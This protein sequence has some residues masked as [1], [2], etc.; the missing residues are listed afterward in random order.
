MTIFWP[1][2]LLIVVVTLYISWRMIRSFKSQSMWSVVMFA[3]MGTIGVLASV[4]LSQE[5]YLTRAEQISATTRIESKVPIPYSTKSKTGYELQ[6]DGNAYITYVYR[7]DKQL[8]Q[9]SVRRDQAILALD[10]GSASIER[11]VTVARWQLRDPDDWMKYLF[12]N[13]ELVKT[14][15]G[16][17]LLRFPPGTV[18]IN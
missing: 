16:K 15:Y 1:T 12:T 2:T 17:W 5:L 18:N 9:F 10:D 7:D 11:E 13:A 14:E 6:Q 3:L 8:E 4:V